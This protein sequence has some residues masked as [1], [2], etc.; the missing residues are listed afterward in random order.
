MGFNFRKPNEYLAKKRT[1][2]DT[3]KKSPKTKDNHSIVC[4]MCALF[5]AI[6]L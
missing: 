1:T 6:V 2:A 3:D 4:F 5:T